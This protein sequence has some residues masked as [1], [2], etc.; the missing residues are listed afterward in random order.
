[1]SRL[2]NDK[3]VYMRAERIDLEKVDQD[4]RFRSYS[5]RE[6]AGHDGAEVNVRKLIELTERHPVVKKP[7]V[8]LISDLEHGCWPGESGEEVVPAEVVKILKKLGFE[9]AKKHYPELRSHVERIEQADITQPLHV[10]EGHVLNGMHR[11][12]AIALAK[13]LGRCEQDFVTAKILNKIPPEA[14]L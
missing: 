8:E 9:E 7:L 13:E 1:M 6:T 3:I 10:F 5:T 2:I 12:C 14:L 11:L 4:P